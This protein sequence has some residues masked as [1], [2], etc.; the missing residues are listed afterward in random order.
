MILAIETSCD[1]SAV[2]LLDMEGNVVANEISSQADLHKKYGGIV[3]EIASR[4]HLTTLPLLLRY[5]MDSYSVELKDLRAV[6]VTY[7]PGLIGS[8]LVGVSYAK[9]LSWLAG[10]PLIPVDHL[11]G[12]LLAPF[13]DHGKMT[14]PYLAL[15]ASG[16][17]THLIV[18]KGL[19][20]YRLLGKTIDDAA[21]EAYDKVAK[22]LGF[23][24][25]GGPIVEKL[26]DGYPNPGID[27]PIPLKGKKTLNFSF[28]GL[29]TA[30]RREA[31]K[32]NV[33]VEGKRL[34]SYEEFEEWPNN[35]K[36][37]MVK[38]IAASFQKIMT[39]IITLRFKE[40]L[41]KTGLK[42]MA[43]T[44]GVASNKGIRRSLE[45]LAVG[46]KKRF[47]YPQN[48]NCTDNAAMIGYTALQYFKTG[49]I[50][51]DHSLHLNAAPKSPI[52]LMEVGLQTEFFLNN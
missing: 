27:F 19:G 35:E 2:A 32:R 48:R 41:N 43:I 23:Q 31:E 52:G 14:F 24:Y 21:G 42:T 4:K 34:I 26:A 12:H 49:Q 40:A 29:K 22:M 15:I 10:V 45:Q 36:K 47:H 28:S 9:T 13:L 37:A 5:V 38:E 44:G 33:Y 8:L 11:E 1:D 39:E 46:R 3:P 16:G 50:D 30:V 25:P 51:L 17:H 20:D 7:A 18:A 6:A